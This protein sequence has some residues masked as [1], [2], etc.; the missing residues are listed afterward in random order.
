MSL[1]MGM[2]RL[3][4]GPANSTWLNSSLVAAE[5]SYTDRKR[6]KSA[7]LSN[8]AKKCDAKYLVQ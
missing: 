7:D 6:I 4:K 3:I 1:D 8:L 5:V 2:E